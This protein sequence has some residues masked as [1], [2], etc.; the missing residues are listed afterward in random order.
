LIRYRIKIKNTGQADTTM[1]HEATHREAAQRKL[2]E[3]AE[4]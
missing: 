2:V 1:E 4:A 3:P